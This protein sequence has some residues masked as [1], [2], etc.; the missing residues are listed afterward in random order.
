MANEEFRF[1]NEEVSIKSLDFSI[2]VRNALLRAGIET[3]GQLLYDHDRD[4]LWDVRNL[5]E[6]GVAEI[7]R[8]LE[9]IH[10]H[11]G[12]SPYS[13]TGA[14]PFSPQNDNPLFLEWGPPQVAV[15]EVIAWQQ[16]A[17]SKQLKA[18]LLHPEV[19]LDG[20]TVGSLVANKNVYSKDLYLKL[21]KI[22]ASHTNVTQELE[23]I[24]S[25]LPPR[26]LEIIRLRFGFNPNTLQS[27]AEEIGV[28]RERVRQLQKKGLARITPVIST[29]PMLRTRSALRFGD[30]LELSYED[31][32]GNL[33]AIGLVGQWTNK[34]LAQYDP[35]EL[36]VAILE[37]LEAT[38][39][40]IALPLSL[41]YILQLR[42]K[43]KTAIPARFMH[44]S[45]A[46]RADERRLILRNLRHSGAIS[47]EWL[48]EDNRITSGRDSLFQWLEAQGFIEVSEGWCMSLV[49][50]HMPQ[51]AQKGSVF[52]S[53][54]FKMSTF[55]GPLSLRDIYFGLEHTLVKTE[56][57]LP[58]LDVLSSV[59]ENYRYTLEEGLWCWYGEMDEALNRGEQVILQ[60]IT[61]G[62]G[63][64]HHNE[65]GQ[66]ILASELS[67][68][69]LHG[70]L[71]RSPLFDKFEHSLYKLRGTQ[72][73]QAQI[74]RAR[75][76]VSQVRV[77]L[78]HDFDMYGNIVVQANLGPL[79]VGHGTI[80]SENLPNLS[81]VWEL[82]TGDLDGSEVVVTD[83]EIRGLRTAFQLIEC[84]VGDRITMKFNT[85]AR[86]VTVSLFGDD[87]DNIAK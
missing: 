14:I 10:I 54:M 64:A 49:G 71:R 30:D 51:A 45:N 44:S 77:D 58:P 66:A 62:N 28:T 18:G 7:E 82:A 8:K 74:E 21:A 15:H 63:V 35:F 41:Q 61:S 73:D 85:D 83:N 38:D 57:P 84:Q 53:A 33:L 31:W 17:L 86:Q 80:T 24:L 36:M 40:A 48:T 50:E 34:K 1:Y 75:R 6:K 69:T 72:P 79:A 70:T 4:A 20:E 9:S 32:S 26:E 39:I 56:F 59:L 78:K 43:G 65:L 52:H 22:L 19:E 46:V 29:R 3:I 68:P 67:Y 42:R 37:L 60:A 23:D 25:P 47:I 5:G 2:R 12:G 81:G 27:I 76:S 87:D 16:A 55:C 11:R 13:E